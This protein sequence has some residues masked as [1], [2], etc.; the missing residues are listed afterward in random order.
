MPL[1][2]V[3]PADVMAP[4]APSAGAADVMAPRAPS[5][6]AADVM[7]PR[8]PSAG[9]ARGAMKAMESSYLTLEYAYATHQT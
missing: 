6:G 2:S 4:R 3:L 9:S 1:N 5:A 7:A 8:A